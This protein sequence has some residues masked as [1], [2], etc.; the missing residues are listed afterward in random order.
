MPPKD[1]S[2]KTIRLD[3]AGPPPLCQGLG[4][5]GIDGIDIGQLMMD[6]PCS[7]H[8]RDMGNDMQWMA[9]LTEDDLSVLEKAVT[10]NPNLPR[11]FQVLWTGFNCRLYDL[12]KFGLWPDVTLPGEVGQ[13]NTMEVGKGED[14]FTVVN[15]YIAK[16]LTNK[17]V[18]LAVHPIWHG[19]VDR[20]RWTD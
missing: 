3:R 4:G 12:L 10:N 5:D 18:R 7:Q 16:D 1:K 13:S 11:L 19:D 15:P 9:S 17:L 20:L 14:K 2:R 6:Q 8:I